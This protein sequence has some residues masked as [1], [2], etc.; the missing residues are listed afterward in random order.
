MSSL[1]FYSGT[2]ELKKMIW[3]KKKNLFVFNSLSSYYN[4]E[5]LTNG[6]KTVYVDHKLS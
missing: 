4:K 5:Y 3:A 6:K 2:K 1:V